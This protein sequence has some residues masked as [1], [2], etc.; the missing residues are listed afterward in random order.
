MS[1]GPI[2]SL[3]DL[4]D[5]LVTRA[6]DRSPAGRGGFFHSANSASWPLNESI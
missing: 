4:S 1:Q 3:Q 5:D 2:L 6:G